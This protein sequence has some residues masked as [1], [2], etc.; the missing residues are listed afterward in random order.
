MTRT[1]H[2]PEKILKFQAAKERS[3]GDHSEVHTCSHEIMWKETKMPG[4][5]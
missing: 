4:K 2:D 1:V 5:L 3:P